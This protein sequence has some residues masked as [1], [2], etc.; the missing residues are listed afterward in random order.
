MRSG[1]APVMRSGPAP[2][3]S[4]GPAPV[5]RSSPLAAIAAMSAMS[6][7]HTRPATDPT[8]R[9]RGRR[10]LAIGGLVAVAVVSFVIALAARGTS[11]STAPPRDPAITQAAPPDAQVDAPPPPDAAPPDARAPTI[12]P[13][14]AAPAPAMTTAVLEVR[15]W[16]DGA[17]VKV[18]EQAHAAPTQFTLPAGHYAIDAEL[19]GWMPERRTIDLD[20]GD[21]VVQEIVFTT[22]LSRGA[23]PAQT[24]KLSARTTPPCEVFLGT[25]R[26]ADTPI[27]DLELA[28]GTYTLAFKHP[29]HAT[30]IRQV[31]IT[32]GKTTKLQVTLP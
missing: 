17:T 8:Q 12:T 3:L 11:P 15:T 4:S 13:D 24:G 14:A 29:R 5:M 19:E 16:P 26:L 7:P 31:T 23:R 6:A 9:Q 25:R 32:A 28:P 21:R 1:P 27:T 10:A 22:E 30:V 2:V 20:G 18:G